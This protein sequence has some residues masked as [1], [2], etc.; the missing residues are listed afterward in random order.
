MAI[1]RINATLTGVQP[2]GLAKIVP[3][4]VAVG[5]GSGSVDA[6]GNVSFSGASSVS[7]NGCFTSI[8]DNYRI[9]LNVT[10]QT[11]DANFNA[12]LRVSNS[13][14]SSSSYSYAGIKVPTGGT[15]TLDATAGT[16][17]WKL[18]ENYNTYDDFMNLSIDLFNP[19]ATGNTKFNSQTFG[20]TTLGAYGTFIQS[21]VF[22][23]TDSFDSITFYP[24]SG[25]INGTV[26]VYGYNQ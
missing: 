8:Y 7:I 22:N 11:G 23:A 21:G 20:G 26:R 24:A 6:N 18:G 1:G 13:D 14:N 15:L 12:R 19:K 2:G 4:S 25:N 17:L 16:T 10:A 5:S 3:T 9:L